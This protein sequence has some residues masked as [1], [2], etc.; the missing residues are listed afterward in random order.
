MT[1]WQLVIFFSLVSRNSFVVEKGVARTHLHFMQ[2]D[3]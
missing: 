3:L 1:I 2:S